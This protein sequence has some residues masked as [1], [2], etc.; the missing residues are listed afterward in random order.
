[1]PVFTTDGQVTVDW[2]DGTVEVLTTAE[3]TFTNGGGYHEIGFRLDS[4]T[5]FNP[6]MFSDLTQAGRVIAV[7]PCPSD[8]AVGGV[9]MFRGCANLDVIDDTFTISGTALNYVFN[10]TGL[11]SL[12]FIDTSEVTIFSSAFGYNNDLTSVPNYDLSNGTA[13]NSM[14]NNVR[15]FDALPAFDMRNGQSFQST[16]SGMR[17]MVTFPLIQIRDATLFTNAWAYCTT[18]EHFP[19]GFFDGWTGTPGN[20]CFQGAWSFA[21]QLTATSVENILNSIDNSGQSAPASG[22][23]ISINHQGTPN[24]STAVTN[25]KARGWEITL[26][27]ILQ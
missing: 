8:M 12:P 24:V 3:H 2:G 11:K 13:F 27:G 18:L 5:N 4:G 17:E 21:N 25:L 14:F 16:W 9:S 10:S 15:N 22:P 26:N 6:Q 7:G 1:M 23:G 19:A 20:S